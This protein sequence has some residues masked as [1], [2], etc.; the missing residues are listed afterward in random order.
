MKFLYIVDYWVPFPQSE[1]GGLIN[2]IGMND[3][4]VFDI[5]TKEEQFNESYQDRILPNV[6]KAQK[7]E[8]NGEYESGIIDA[9]LT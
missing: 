5:L 2:V 1:Y 9:F 4:E 3:A 8:L 6:M 7:L